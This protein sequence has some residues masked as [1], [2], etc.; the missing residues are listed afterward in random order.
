MRKRKSQMEILGLAIII[1]LVIFAVL[2]Y[3]MFAPSAKTPLE[4]DRDLTDTKLASSTLDA[5][6]RST[7]DCNNGRTDQEYSVTELLQ[8]CVYWDIIQCRRSPTDI[9]SVDSCKFARGKIGFMLN[10]TL[11]TWGRTYLLQTNGGI[12]GRMGSIA[13]GSCSSSSA[14]RKP[15]HQPIPL[16]AGVLNVT[17]R[18]CS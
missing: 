12:M 7:I 2:L 10:E 3:L 4:Q 6:L 5:I 17:L 18:I 16:A 11:R 9:T 15:A 13:S 1:V 8:D 14:A